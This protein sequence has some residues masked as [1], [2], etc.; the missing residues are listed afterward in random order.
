MRLDKSSFQFVRLYHAPV[1]IDQNR[2]LDII[3]EMNTAPKNDWHG[4]NIE[5]AVL[6]EESVFLD[7]TPRSMNK[8]IDK[9]F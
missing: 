2:K 7:V 9:G 3:D 5:E 4:L 1:F 6:T 8:G